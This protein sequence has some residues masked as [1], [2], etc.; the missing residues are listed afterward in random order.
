M[1]ERSLPAPSR[2]SLGEPWALP[3]LITYLR[4]AAIPVV[5]FTMS[6]SSPSASFWAAVL[7]GLASATDALDGYLA[8]KMKLISVYGQL[9]DPM[10]DKLLVT[11]V[12]VM[13]VAMDRLSAALVVV[14]LARETFVSGLRSMAA[15]FGLVIAARNLGK[16]KTAFQMVGIFCLLVHYTHPFLGGRVSYHRVGLVFLL[17]SVGFSLWS[18][19][20][21]IRLFARATVQRAR[22]AELEG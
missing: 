5:M 9:L 19:W 11:A 3:N 17:I 8:R 7:F 4:I 14:I 15:S 13:L 1:S 2:P 21:Y 12:L 18:A 6:F 10:A 16:Y 22:A 20:D